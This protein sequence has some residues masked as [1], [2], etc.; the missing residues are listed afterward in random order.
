[1]PREQGRQRGVSTS[2]REMYVQPLSPARMRFSEDNTETGDGTAEP[3][4]TPGG[5]VGLYQA[6]CADC[7]A[8]PTPVW[9]CS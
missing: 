7:R 5:L 8:F 1:M 6:F 3:F 4:A 2:G 9:F